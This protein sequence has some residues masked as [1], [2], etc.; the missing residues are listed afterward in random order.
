[1]TR[2]EAAAQNKPHYGIESVDHAL[3]LAAVLQQEGPLRVS[4]AAERWWP[5]LAR[6]TRSW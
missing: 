3:H 2:R 6:S 5:C 4:E 1:M